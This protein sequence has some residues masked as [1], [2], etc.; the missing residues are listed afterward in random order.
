MLFLQAK[1]R[2]EMLAAQAQ[3]PKYP[4]AATDVLPPPPPP[5][6]QQELDP[7]A[8]FYAPPPAPV[9]NHHIKYAASL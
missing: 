3:A 4:A 6:Y 5:M 8:M 7:G 9:A 1:Q 2:N